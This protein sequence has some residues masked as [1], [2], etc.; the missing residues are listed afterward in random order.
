MTDKKIFFQKYISKDIDCVC[1]SFADENMFTNHTDLPQT[2]DKIA[3]LLKEFNIHKFT[4]FINNYNTT[5][6]T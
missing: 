2:I 3:E 6:I 1:Y 4:A 5:E